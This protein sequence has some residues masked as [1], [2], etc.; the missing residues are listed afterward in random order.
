MTKKSCQGKE[1][2][3]SDCLHTLETPHPP[4]MAM[5]YTFWIC[6]LMWCRIC[7][8][9][10]GQRRKGK[11]VQQSVHPGESTSV[12]D[13]WWPLPKYHHCSNCSKTPLRGHTSKG[14]SKTSEMACTPM[15]SPASS[16]AS[17]ICWRF[18]PSGPSQSEPQEWTILLDGIYWK[19]PKALHCTRECVVNLSF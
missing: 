14:S 5:Q 15:P 12:L 4:C 17:Q 8:Y 1:R 7:T 2:Q 18:P 16:S 6:V 9:R 13:A 19:C 10:C 11:L 3:G